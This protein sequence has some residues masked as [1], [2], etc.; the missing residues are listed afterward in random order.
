M[1]NSVV[2]GIAQALDAEFGEDH[3]IYTESIKQGFKE[4][5][6]FIS[7]VSS[8][9][10]TA[11]GNRRF[12]ENLLC[13]QYFPKDEQR[14]N[15]EC[16]EVMDRLVKC[17]KYI[18]VDGD[19]VMG[20]KMNGELTDGFLSFFVN[21]DYYTYLPEELTEMG[22]LERSVYAKDRESGKEQ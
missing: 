16:F 21:Y 14:G 5:C 11:L 18:T 19:L 12:S 22:E 3:T 1:T 2:K 17:L 7:L 9:N 4:P 20:R 8:S 13:V 15:E 6:F 10:K